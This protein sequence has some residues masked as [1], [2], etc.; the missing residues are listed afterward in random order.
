MPDDF[1]QTIDE[2]SRYRVGITTFEF[3]PASE[4]Y[5]HMLYLVAY[6]IRDSKR[7]RRVAKTCQDYGL[8]VEYSVF[9][10][11]LAEEVF[12]QLWRE[13]LAAMDPEE[14]AILAYRICGACVSKIESAGAVIRPGKVLLYMA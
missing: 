2:F 1:E 12:G 11:D 14:D 4:K 6:D 5:K 8:R 7:L 9:E 10:C 3:D 13:L